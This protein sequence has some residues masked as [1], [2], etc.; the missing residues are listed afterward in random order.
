L[1]SLTLL[2]IYRLLQKKFT[3]KKAVYELKTQIK[4]YSHKFYIPY[5]WPIECT[6]YI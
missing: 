1:T 3:S 6:Y 4:E 2:T 5:N